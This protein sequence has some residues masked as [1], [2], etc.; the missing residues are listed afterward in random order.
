MFDSLEAI[1]VHSSNRASSLRQAD[2]CPRAF[3]RGSTGPT[4][5]VG[6][7]HNRH[8][9]QA[10]RRCGPYWGQYADSGE[11]DAY[12]VVQSS[13]TEVVA[14]GDSSVP[15]DA[16][17]LGHHPPVVPHQRHVGSLERHVRPSRARGHARVSLSLRRA[18]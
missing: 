15:T 6:V 11:R 3:A 17:S 12:Y 16:D 5:V 14:D 10:L 13:E 4:G 7:E 9:R 1:A 2:H 8:V 18:G